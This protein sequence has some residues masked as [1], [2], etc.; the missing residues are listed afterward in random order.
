VGASRLATVIRGTGLIGT[1]RHFSEDCL[2]APRLATPLMVIG[3]D[4]VLPLD[5][6]KVAYLRVEA[7]DF[8]CHH[9]HG[10]GSSV[11]FGGGR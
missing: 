7:L 1:T 10:S 4:V 8:D 11:R 5:L 3:D 2:L 6:N 9:S